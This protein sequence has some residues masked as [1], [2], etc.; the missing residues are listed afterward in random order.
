MLFWIQNKWHCSLQ[1]HRTP[2]RKMGFTSR[3]AQLVCRLLPGVLFFVIVGHRKGW[4]GRERSI[5]N[6][7]ITQEKSPRFQPLLFPAGLNRCFSSVESGGFW[8]ALHDPF[9]VSENVAKC[10]IDLLFHLKSNTD[11]L[12]WVKQ[13]LYSIYPNYPS[14]AGD[15]REAQT[16]Q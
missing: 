9:L 8:R 15:T 16:I 5:S 7:K 10:F 13:I 1:S 3:F 2:L 14:S 11:T 4:A 12:T 6:N